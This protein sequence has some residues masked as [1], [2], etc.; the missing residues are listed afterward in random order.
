[1]LSPQLLS[2][3]LAG[4]RKV[5]S[6]ECGEKSIASNSALRNAGKP[7]DYGN[8]G[9]A[10]FPNDRVEALKRRKVRSVICCFIVVL[11]LLVCLGSY[12]GMNF[13]SLQIMAEVISNIFKLFTGVGFLF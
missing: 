5:S 11:L 12:E 2:K 4:R 8:L 10:Q 1:M 7:K 3:A 6:T 13:F 9:T